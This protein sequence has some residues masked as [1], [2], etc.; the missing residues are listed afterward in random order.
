MRTSFKTNAGPR[1]SWIGGLAVLG[2]ALFLCLSSGSAMAAL[3]LVGSPHVTHS[4]TQ[5]FLEDGVT[6]DQVQFLM[7]SGGPFEAPA[8]TGFSDG[9]WAESC[10]NTVLASATG[11]ALNSMTWTVNFQGASSSPLSFYFQALSAGVVVQTAFVSWDGSSWHIDNAVPASPSWNGGSICGFTNAVSGVE[12]QV[13]L[14]SDAQCLTIP[15]DIV[16]NNLPQVQAYSVTFKLNN[17]AF[18]STLA[19]SVTAGNYLSQVGGTDF[20]RVDNGDG[21]YTVDCAILGPACGNGAQ[22]GNLFNV[23][24]KGVSEGLGSLQI[25]SVVAR[26]CQNTAIACTF[27]P[28]V[29][30]TFDKTAPLAIADLAASRLATGNG[31]SGIRK[32]RLTWSGSGSD[33]VT[34]Y[35]EPY[36]NYPEYGPL[37][38]GSWTQ[39]ATN[40]TSPYDDVPPGRDYWYYRATVTDGCGNTSSLS[41][42]T[43]GTLDYVLGDVV[44]PSSVSPIGDNV[45]DDADIAALGGSY[46]LTGGA[47]AAVGYLDVGPTTDY[48]VNGRPTPDDVIGFEDLVM[49]ALDYG[50]SVQRPQ[51]ASRPIPAAANQ[52]DI[53]TPDQVSSGQTFTAVLHMQGAGDIQ[54]LS[55]QLSWDRSVAEP[56]SVAAGGLITSQNGV[57]FSSGPGSVDAALLGARDQALSGDGELATVTFRAV[58]SGSPAITL[59][60]LS[61]RDAKNQPVALG[62]AGRPVGGALVT[63]LQ[64]AGANP[65]R[66]SSELA[67]SLAKA[68]P[69]T[70]AIYS[71][72]GRK[73]RTLSAGTRDAGAYRA[74][75]NG[76]D[77]SGN[78][79]QPGVFFARLVTASG[80]LSRAITL[81]R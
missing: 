69:M 61:A 55:A 33:V 63:S 36:G 75:W 1:R 27:G 68:G 19:G 45:V 41:N 34:L 25:L 26:D 12:P 76:L 31:A 57:V 18:C 52:V 48:S 16:R 56:V 49:F 78:R 3:H 21:T 50:T 58:G 71:V 60:K 14:T 80:Q 43:S 4:W 74:I 13:C 2:A 32:I 37:P 10:D 79:M 40:V 59:A 51:F 20:H 24:V 46:G 35:R 47:V 15:I 54:A 17:L 28:L 38:T 44:D 53:V 7:T 23:S 9:S 11:N 66:G 70:L 73:V 30:V 22:Q 39:V 67:Y 62:T 81:L 72:D 65:F 6:F 64:S 29:G 42:T 5:A 77:D 8:E